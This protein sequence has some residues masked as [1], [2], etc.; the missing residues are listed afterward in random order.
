M[1]ILD[2]EFNRWYISRE[3]WMEKWAR[4]V[5]EELGEDYRR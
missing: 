2:R 1:G 4:E 5:E 3:I